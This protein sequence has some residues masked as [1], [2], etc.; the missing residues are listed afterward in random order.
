MDHGQ[1]YEAAITLLDRR[2]IED[3]AD[4]ATVQRAEEI[5][6]QAISYAFYEVHVVA[7]EPEKLTGCAGGDGIPAG[8]AVVVANRRESYANSPRAVFHPSRKGDDLWAAHK[9]LFALTRRI[10]LK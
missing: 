1:L 4:L 3:A 6:P 2:C 8:R 9:G 5:T 10:A 7:N